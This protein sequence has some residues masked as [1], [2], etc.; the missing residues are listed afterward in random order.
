MRHFFLGF[1]LIFSMVSN[2]WAD[3]ERE[4]LINRIKPVGQVD[5]ELTADEQKKM[6]SIE[7]PKSSEPRTPKFIYQKH[8]VVCHDAGIAG[9]PV[10]RNKKDWSERLSSKK[11]SGLTKTA[12]SGINA[13][14]VR[15][16]CLDCTDDEIKATIEYMLPTS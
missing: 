14:P 5:I 12:I 8:C 4:Q 16:T 1:A 9:A 7:A 2:V 13:M 10:F 15:G 11:L 3:V 6:S